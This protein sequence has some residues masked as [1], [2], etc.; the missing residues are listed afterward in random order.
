MGHIWGKGLHDLHNKGMVDGFLD[1]S[2]GFDFCEN[3]VYGK[4]SQVRF[5]FGATRVKGIL[6]L[7]HSDVFVPVPVP[8]LGGSLYYISFIDDFSSN[9]WL[10]FLKKK[11]E[12][13]SKFKVCKDL[14]ENQTCKKIEV[15]RTDNRGEFYGKEF[16]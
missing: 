2:S 12:V 9:T 5:P 6:Q 1:C 11:S 13:F 14:V 4:Q 3:C 7:I 10:Y 15:L 8:S 16:D